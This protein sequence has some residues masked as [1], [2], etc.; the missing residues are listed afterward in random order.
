MS[1]KLFAF[2]L[3]E[4]RLVRVICKRGGCGG[5]LELPITELYRV[6]SATCPICKEDFHPSGT[7]PNT[8]G[9]LK[10][11]IEEALQAKDKFAIEFVIPDESK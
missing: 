6:A 5:T 3:S 7:D 8:F 2:L 11:A 4:L 9:K 10:A 1:R